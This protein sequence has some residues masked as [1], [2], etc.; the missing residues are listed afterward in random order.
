MPLAK[1]FVRRARLL[2]LL[3]SLSLVPLTARAEDGITYETE[4]LANGLTVI[5]APMPTSPVTHVRVLYHVGSRDERADRQG[6]AH[7]FEHMMFRGS[8]HVKPEEHMKLVGMVGGYSNAFTSFDKTVYVDTIPNN[9]ADMALWLEAD[10]MSSFKVSAQIFG[11]EREVVQKE[12]GMRQN[13]PY[14]TAFEELLATTFKKHPYRWTPIGNMEQLHKAQPSEL[15]AF[16]NKYYVPNN[17]ILVIAGGSDMAKMKEKVKQYFGWIPKGAD[18]VRDLPKE[19]EQ[20]EARRVTVTKKVPLPRIYITYRM[21]PAASDDQDPIGVMLEILGGGQSSR[22]SRALVTN[23]DPLC[24]QADAVAVDLE[25]GGVMGAEATVLQGKDPASVEKVLNEQ[26]AQIAER[27]VTADELEKAKQQQRLALAKRFETAEKVASELG[28]EMLT[29]GN[30]NRINTA[31]ARLEAITVDDVQRVAKKYF[32]E[33]KS[34]TL[35]IKP[36]VPTEKEKAEAPSAST[37]QPASQPVEKQQPKPVDFPADYPKEPPMS[38]KVP[39]AVFEKGVEKM[40]SGVR[41]IVMEDHRIPVVNWSLTMRQGGYVE[42]AGKEGLADLTASMVRRGPTGKTFDQFNEEL[43]SRGI[44]LS[45]DDGGD[46]TRVSGFCLKEQ[47]PFGLAATHDILTTPAFNADEFRRLK[48]QADSGLR[49]SLNNPKTVGSRKLS[50]ALYGDSPLGRL[51]TIES[52]TS[53]TLDDVKQFFETV[54]RPT[55]AVLMISGDITVADGQA[56]AEKIVTGMKAGT[57]PKATYDFPAIPEKRRIILVDRPE[58]KQSSIRIGIR[59]FDITSD[60][61]FPGMLAGQMLSS[62]IDSR[63]GRYVRAEKG[64]VYG[65]GAYFLPARESGS[66]SGSTD[67]RCETTAA[68]IEAMFK[69]FDDMRKETVPEKELADAKFRVAGQLLMGMQTTE[70]QA[71][72]RVEALLNHYPIDYYDKYAERIGQ[73]TADDVKAVMDK[74]VLPDRMIITV[75]APASEVKEQLEKLGDVEVVPMPLAK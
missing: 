67:T 51:T 19:P 74:Y 24:V 2:T 63:L 14:G 32:Q 18:L 39:A 34:T 31:R 5:Y 61:K 54:Y 21:P 25:D 71:S 4:K 46:Y 52:I 1:P 59:A 60:E 22:L 35:M 64:Y 12:W 20:T 62:G 65:V 47:L 66:F 44:E 33:A 69:V 8:E 72:R 30:L 58:A 10:R 15:Q 3:V 48:G 26:I 23:S 73:V 9:Y 38:G 11:I 68:T 57:L 43:E 41:V 29:R 42:P 7:M 13:Q 37:S 17:A 40:V 50:H 27:P 56:A 75:V 16:F 28:D 53:I 6:F 70:Q 36:G 45:V 55:D 49:L